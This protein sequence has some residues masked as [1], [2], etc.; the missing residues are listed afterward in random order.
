MTINL[1]LLGDSDISRWPST[2]Y[3]SSASASSINNLTNYA[4]SGARIGDVLEQISMWENS[5]NYP[6]KDHV[7]G[8][9]RNNHGTRTDNT[10]Y[11][12]D[13]IPEDRSAT[14]RN[15]FICCV[16]ENDVSSTSTTL[17]RSAMLEKIISDFRDVLDALFPSTA[18]SKTKSSLSS[19][20]KMND[21]AMLNLSCT[22]SHSN[23]QLLSRDDCNKLARRMI[24]FG[25]KYEPWLTHDAASR[26]LY[27]KL[28]SGLRRVV[29]THP[30]SNCILFIEC[31]TMFCTIPT[32]VGVGTVSNRRRDSGAEPDAKYFHSDGF[33]LSDV[34]YGIWKRIVEEE[35][36]RIIAE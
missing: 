8:S 31:L 2:M 9:G 29:N 19:T 23:P 17:G 13:N 28:N 22:S 33:N 21:T 26:K 27:T 11:C 10:K 35:I 4:R 24:F 20:K 36:T 34:G 6:S 18:T 16:G 30:A 3:P 5:N 12:H 15:I 32:S 25:P 1:T 7:S 14:N